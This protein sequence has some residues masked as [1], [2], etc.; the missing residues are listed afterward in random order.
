MDR[1]CGSLDH[2]WLSVHGE[3]VTMGRRNCSRAREVIVVAR[4]EKERRSSG[5]SPMVS[6]RDRAAE[7]D[8]R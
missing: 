8:I 7:M 6:L 2:G 3:L 5:F 1:T 4:G